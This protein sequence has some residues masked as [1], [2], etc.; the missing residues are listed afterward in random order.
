MKIYFACTGN[1]EPIYLPKNGLKTILCSFHYYRKKLDIIQ[2]LIADGTD[3]FIDSGAFSAN[4]I[5]APIDID[6]YCKFL[7]DTGASHYVCLDVIHNA[8]ETY[9]NLRYMEDQGLSPFPVFHKGESE[10]WLMLYLKDYKKL[11]LGGAVNNGTLT[12]WLDEVW[13]IILRVNPTIEVHGFG[14]TSADIMKRYPW[15][16]CDSSSFKSG[17]RFGRLIF[18]NAHKKSFYTENF[19]LW[20]QQYAERENVPEILTESALRY[21]ITDVFSAKSYQQFVDVE[22]GTDRK[23]EHLTTQYGLF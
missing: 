22:C 9:K 2:N 1:G 8:P 15:H 10:E 12:T 11:A 7:K 23:Y 17:K 18:Y 19:N 6:E 5:G 3:V 13:R 4:N 21:E 16:S 20:V 14:I